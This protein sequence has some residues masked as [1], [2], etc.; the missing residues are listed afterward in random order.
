METEIRDASSRKWPHVHI[1]VMMCA[2]HAKSHKAELHD[3][4]VG[5]WD[6]GPEAG[7]EQGDTCRQRDAVVHADVDDNTQ[8]GPCQ[9]SS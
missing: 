2:H 6:G 5:D 3:V 4:S 1:C 9:T 8:A 7:V